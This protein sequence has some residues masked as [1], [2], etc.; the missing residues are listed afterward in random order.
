MPKVDGPIFDLMWSDPSELANGFTPNPLG[1]S[2][3]FGMEEAHAFLD[4]IDHEILVRSHEMVAG[5][6][7]FPFDPD[8]TV[9]TVF[10]APCAGFEFDSSGAVMVISTALECS[11][12]VIKPMERRMSS[13]KIALSPIDVILSLR[14]ASSLSRS[15]P[16]KRW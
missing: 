13:A 10:S 1:E 5:G 16:T 15:A 11:F 3:C 12:V 4:A 6:F 8:R 14:P 7:E 2:F 9:V